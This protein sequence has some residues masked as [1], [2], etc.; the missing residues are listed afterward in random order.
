MT[1][2]AVS[3]KSAMIDVPAASPSRPSVRF[4]AFAAPAMTKKTSTYQPQPSGIHLSHD[5]DEDGV[6]ELL[7]VRRD[8]DDHRDREQEQHLDP[9]RQ[10]E[11][12]AVPQLD[13]VVG[14]PDRAAGEHRPED[15]QRGQRAD[16]RREER[17]RRGEHDQHAAH[18]RRAL[19]DRVVLRA[20]LADRLAERVAAQEVDEER[21]GE[22]RDDERDERRDEDVCHLAA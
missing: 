12:A 9:A 1:A 16:G 17:D 20:L 2:I 7:V 3:V 10:A 15:R 11:R 13:Q 19:L 6:A 18:R 22:D 4:T 21:A 14:E 8:A 5:R